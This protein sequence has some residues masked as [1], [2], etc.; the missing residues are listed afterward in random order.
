MARR[1]APQ[2]KA[3]PKAPENKEPFIEEDQETED[4]STEDE[5][6]VSAEEGDPDGD[7][8]TDLVIRDTQLRRLLKAEQNSWTGVISR[9]AFREIAERIR[10]EL[11]GKA[12]FEEDPNGA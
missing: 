4:Q 9:A 12:E 5:G 8:L 11:N 7:E 6:D 2:N 10:A 3:Q 1:G